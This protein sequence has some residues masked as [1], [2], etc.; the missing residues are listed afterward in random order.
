MFKVR[1]TQRFSS[2]NEG[3][4]SKGDEWPT[5]RDRA[6]AL[7]GMGVVEIL[8]GDSTHQDFETKRVQQLS[9]RRDLLPLEPFDPARSG[10]NSLASASTTVGA[11]IQVPPASTLPTDT[12]GSSATP[13]DSGTSTS[14][15]SSSAAGSS[16]RTQ[17]QPKSTSSSSSRS[18][19]A[20]ALA[21][22]KT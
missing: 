12:G 18:K 7:A 14:S 3:H 10:A 13:A 9:S 17:A 2:M 11:S 16:P 15:A 8:E 6:Y 22:K 1:A 21:S 20:K 19:G 4:K 5:S